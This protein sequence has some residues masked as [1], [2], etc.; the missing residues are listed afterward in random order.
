[1]RATFMHAS[2]GKSHTPTGLTISMQ[3]QNNQLHNPKLKVLTM[4]EVVQISRAIESVSRQGLYKDYYAIRGQLKELADSVT[5]SCDEIAK[6]QERSG[7]GSVAS[8]H[9]LKLIV[10]ALLRL[11]HYAFE[12]NG[13]VMSALISWCEHSISSTEKEAKAANPAPQLA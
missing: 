10:D 2:D 6:R 3:R 13:R 12:Y 1:L 4:T 7:A 9:F 8:L 11:T 5:R